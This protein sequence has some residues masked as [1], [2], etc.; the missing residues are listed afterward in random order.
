M[1]KLTIS[2][3]LEREYDRYSEKGW[4]LM[5]GIIQGLLLLKYIPVFGH[6]IWPSTLELIERNNI[7]KWQ[8]VFYFTWIY[9]TLW[10]FFINILFWCVYKLEHPL[11]ER[12]KVHNEPWPWKQ[13]Y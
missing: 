8:F 1:K 11:F 6:W 13:N 2:T 5:A 3:L 7:E 4:G 9:N 12:S 10:Y